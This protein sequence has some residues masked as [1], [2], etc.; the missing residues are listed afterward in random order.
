MKVSHIF[1]KGLLALVLA[2][3]AGLR[4]QAYLDSALPVDVRVA[5]LLSRMT[6]EEKIAELNAVQWPSLEEVGSGRC[7]TVF[8]IQGVARCRAFQSARLKGSRL[9]IPLLFC[10][11]LPHGFRTVFPNTLAMAASWDRTLIETC[12]AAMAGEASASGLHLLVTDGAAVTDDPRPVSA[13]NSAGEDPYLASVVTAATIQ[14][15]QGG[16]LSGHP[17]HPAACLRDFIA[18]GASFGGRGVQTDAV[19]ERALRER[20]LPPFRRAVDAGAAAMMCAPT[21]YNGVPMVFEPYTLRVLLRNELGFQGPVFSDWDAMNRAVWAGAAGDGFEAVCRA[22][23]SGVDADRASGAFAKYLKRALAE[24]KVGLPMLDAAVSRVLE[25]KFRM[26]LFEDPFAFCDE[27][28]ERRGL[29]ADAVRALAFRMACSSAVLLQNRGG[30][31]PLT[32]FSDMHTAETVSEVAP[33]ALGTHSALGD[34]E[35][36]APPKLALVGPF[37]ENRVSLQGG[38][39]SES[40]PTETVT[41]AEGFRDRMSEE[42]LIVAGCLLGGCTKSYLEGLTERLKDAA[43][44]VAC[45]GGSVPALTASRSGA[46][47]ELP[48]DQLDLLRFLKTLGKPVV[49]VLFNDRPAVLEEVAAL[50][51]AVL[52]AWQPGSLGGAAVAALLLGEV[53]PSGRLPMSFPRHAG[54]VPILYCPRRSCDSSG[55]YDVKDGPLFPFGFGLSYS[56]FSYSDPVLAKPVYACGDSIEVSVKVTNTGTVAA[57]EVVQVY[58]RDEAASVVPREQE[59]RGFHRLMLQPGETHAINFMM[60]PSAFSVWDPAMRFVVEPGAFCIRIGGSSDATKETRVIF[61]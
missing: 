18:S 31:L 22:L 15:I 14:G 58:V 42:R 28:R 26:R 60:P 57:A 54:Q 24:G 29:G 9:G 30:V 49:T 50:S 16:E 35:T 6:P 40:R 43:V 4:A 39:T 19:S 13:A 32:A 51:D 23:R 52:E 59:L 55:Y 10:G 47:L 37:V 56:T 12:A 41:V 20:F 48:R 45:L 25:L 11:E 8:G 27:D 1:G 33:T 53:S 5:D 46:T 44:I 36:P 61:E 21:Y 34:R 17:A 7:G 2:A 38:W 3:A